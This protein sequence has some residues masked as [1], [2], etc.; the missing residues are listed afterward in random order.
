MVKK[1]KNDGLRFLGRFFQDCRVLGDMLSTLTEG[2]IVQAAFLT[3]LMLLIA[4]VRMRTGIL[5]TFANFCTLA[6]LQVVEEM[7]SKFKCF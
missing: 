1:W 7:F 2:P 5:Q 4:A 6:T 3:F